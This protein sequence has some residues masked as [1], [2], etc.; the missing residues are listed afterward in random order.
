M[1]EEVPIEQNPDGIKS[2]IYYENRNFKK[3][4]KWRKLLCIRIFKRGTET[5][6]ELKKTVAE[7]PVNKKTSLPYSVEPSWGLCSQPCL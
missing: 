3:S 1:R 4:I 7:L 5:T 2:L 6:Q